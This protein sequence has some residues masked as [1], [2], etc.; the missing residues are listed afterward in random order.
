ML[1]MLKDIS[2]PLCNNIHF[3]KKL[4]KY[5]LAGKNVEPPFMANSESAS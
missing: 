3:E 2:T 1:V 5:K 4:T